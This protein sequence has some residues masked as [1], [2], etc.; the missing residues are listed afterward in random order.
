MIVDTVSEGG[1]TPQSSEG[2][3]DDPQFRW[4]ERTLEAANRRDELIFVFSHHA[5]SSSRGDRRAR[6]VVPALLRPRDEHGHDANPGCSRDPRASTPIHLG[7]D[8]ISLLHRFAYVAGHSHENAI[9]PIKNS[10]GGGYW[11]L[12][13]PAVADW[14]THH[15]LLE[16]MDN[17]DGTLSLFRTLLDFDSPVRAPGSGPT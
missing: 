15:R 1:Q 11:E 12:K 5:P 9:I 8:T 6:R 10:R 3:I 17:R 16:V 4:L 2:N 7:D 14:T 13:S